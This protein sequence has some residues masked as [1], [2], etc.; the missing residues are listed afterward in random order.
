MSRC[1]PHVA[2]ADLCL[3][4]VARYLELHVSHQP[5]WGMMMLLLLAPRAHAVGESGIPNMISWG[6]RLRKKKYGNEN[7]FMTSQ[8]THRPK[9]V[10]KS[11]PGCL[12]F[13]S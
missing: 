1:H 9:A 5:L 8:V 10:C 13:G 11:Q 7:D 4:S 2:A 3:A 12:A 6:E